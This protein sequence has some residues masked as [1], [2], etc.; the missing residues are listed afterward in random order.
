MKHGAEERQS[1]KGVLHTSI[2]Y[3]EFDDTTIG[4]KYERVNFHAEGCDVF[5]LKFTS[6]MAFDE[7]GFS[8]TAIT[9]QDALD[10]REGATEKTVRLVCRLKAWLSNCVG[11]GD[12]TGAKTSG[13][14]YLECWN[15]FLWWIHCVL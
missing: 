8:S 13:N 1:R 10:N 14:P 3:V 7:C 9:D 6:Q 4:V 11:V 15:L 2:P 12:T 5:L